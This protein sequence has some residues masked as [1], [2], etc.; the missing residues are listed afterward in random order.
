MILR[1]LVTTISAV[2]ACLAMASV[3]TAAGSPPTAP[4]PGR[5]S[6]HGRI[7][8]ATGRLREDRDG[9][10]LAL[11]RTTGGDPKA[12]TITLVG[13]RCHHR[14]HCSRVAGTLR[15]TM[16]SRPSRP[17]I[18]EQFALSLKGNVRPLGHVTARGTAHGTGFITY[19]YE[20]LDLTLADASASV[21]I[22]AQS[23]RVPGFTSP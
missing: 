13:R 10:Q 5:D 22:D 3:A 23:A 8:S 19:G 20:S 6:F 18:G 1:M 15:G 14:R 17:D 2:T 16:V 21:T 12:V 4:V 7:T 11:L 9:V